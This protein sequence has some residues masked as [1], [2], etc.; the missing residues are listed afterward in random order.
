MQRYWM[1]I[2][3]KFPHEQTFL[4]SHSKSLSVIRECFTVNSI[5]YFFDANHEVVFYKYEWLFSK[6]WLFDKESK[7]I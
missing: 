3:D 5:V 2:N 6:Y 4:V 1:L 7:T